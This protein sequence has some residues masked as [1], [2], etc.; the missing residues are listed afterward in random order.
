MSTEK[1]VLVC[2]RERKRI[3][4]LPNSGNEEQLRAS[5]FQTF[6]DVLPTEIEKVF[7]QVK[8]EQWGGEFLDLTEGQEIVD[9]SILNMIV[10]SKQPQVQYFGHIIRSSFIMAYLIGCNR[11][12]TS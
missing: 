10:V 1:K 2:F 6:I 7:F 12:Q 4:C 9:R 8:D 3:V 11:Q 5:A